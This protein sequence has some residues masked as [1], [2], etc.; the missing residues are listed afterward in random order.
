MLDFPFGRDMMGD[1]GRIENGRLRRPTAPG[2]GIS[3]TPEMEASYPYDAS[4]VYSCMLNDWGPP[5]D[6]YWSL[7]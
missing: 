3:L 1:Q 2:L 7:S 6:S 4:A 5:P